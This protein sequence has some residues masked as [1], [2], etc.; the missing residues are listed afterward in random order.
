MTRAIWL[1]AVAAF[2]TICVVGASKEAIS[3]CSASCQNIPGTNTPVGAGCF[4]TSISPSLTNPQDPVSYGADPTGVND[5]T[6][7]IKS[8]MAVGDVLFKTPGSYFINTFTS[9]HGIILPAGR[10]VKCRAGVTIF[11][12][13]NNVFGDW[14]IFETVNGGNTIVGCTIR[15]GNTAAG[16]Q[17]QSNQ[18]GQFL[19][20]VNGA[21]VTVEGNTLDSTWGNS[22]VQTNSDFI[23][24]APANFVIQ[25]NTFTHNPNYGPNVTDANGGIVQNNLIQDSSVGVENESC[26]NSPPHFTHNVTVKNNEITVSVGNCG[27]VGP[28]CSGPMNLTGGTAPPTCDY[29][30]N[31]VSGNYCTGKNGVQNVL[32]TNTASGTSATYTGDILGPHCTCDSGSSC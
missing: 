15:G 16:A 22:A 13:A 20:L 28:P 4:P 2:L 18:E 27:V 21:N 1:F 32:I 31:V 6:A 29:T 24:V 25:Y 8:A 12:T 19:V 3:Q 11:E 26:T 30:T 5:S 7:A 14:G 9:N 17:A 23:G 10:V